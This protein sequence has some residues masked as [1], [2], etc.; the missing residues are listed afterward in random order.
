LL[1]HPHIHCIVTGG[2]LG[3]DG[4]VAT[5]PCFLF[6]VGVMRKLFA[7]LVRTRLLEA[8]EHLDLGR[9]CVPFA[10]RKAFVRLLRQLR[11]KQWVVYVKKPFMGAEGVFRYI[12]Q[13]TH[14]VGISDHRLLEVTDERVVFRTRGAGRE[15]VTPDEFI[16][17]F[18]LHIL[19]DKFHK[20]R[21]YGL[22][23][24]SPLKGKL[25]RARSALIAAGAA[26]VHDH[27][28]VDAENVAKHRERRRHCPICATPLVQ[29]PL[30]HLDTLFNTPGPEVADTA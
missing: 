20:I 16:H 28:V 7:R 9:D 24:A 27:A 10:N 8:W 23:A 6:S 19:P 2:G 1:F 14:R 12:G 17:R 18:L 22:Y 3:A 11:R 26:A 21:H 30:W 29:L 5:K 25:E 13:Y 4:W 15:T